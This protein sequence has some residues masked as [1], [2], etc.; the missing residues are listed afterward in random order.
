MATVGMLD[1][2]PELAAGI[3]PEE[4]GAAQQALRAPALQLR[5]GAWDA[6]TLSGLADILLGAVVVEGRLQRTLTLGVRST[7][8]L[9]GPGDMVRP[10]DDVEP[11]VP[12]SVAWQACVDTELAVLDRRF[13]AAAARWPGVLIELSRRGAR[14]TSRMQL[15]V[16]IGQLS[17]VDDRVLVL[18]WR[19]GQRW[20]RMTPGGVAVRL[21]LTH[22][23]I[24]KLVGATRPPVSTAIGE[25]TRSGRVQRLPDGWL[26]D[27]AVEDRVGQL[28][29]ADDA[30]GARRVERLVAPGR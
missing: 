15:Q 12:E 3:P 4:L 6:S 30:G 18:L 22:A 19:L 20:G 13:V 5:R 16:G 21:A 2:D 29:S 27:P 11:G 25:L 7:A 28:L 24:A 14:Q 17:R 26:L 23:A 8:H 1:V 10:W 9:F